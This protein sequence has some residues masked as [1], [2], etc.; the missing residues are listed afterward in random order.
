MIIA[1]H[2]RSNAYSTLGVHTMRLARASK[3]AQQIEI[4]TEVSYVLTISQE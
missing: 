4:E 3:T 2:M 1:I